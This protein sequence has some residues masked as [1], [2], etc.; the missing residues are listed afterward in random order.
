MLGISVLPPR[1]SDP[2]WGISSRGHS[3]GQCIHSGASWISRAER[4]QLG[5]N[6]KAYGLGLT[7]WQGPFPDMQRWKVPCLSYIYLNSLTLKRKKNPAVSV[8]VRIYTYICQDDLIF[9][10]SIHIQHFRSVATG[11][12]RS[13]CL[14]KQVRGRQEEESAMSWVF[15]MLWAHSH[16]LSHVVLT[17]K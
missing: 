14:Q 4:C 5:V 3:S 12:V 2:E 6:V 16:T 10:D 1:T 8:C 13:R 7:Q 11:R 17:A 9:Q 15:I